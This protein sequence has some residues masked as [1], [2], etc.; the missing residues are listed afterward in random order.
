VRRKNLPDLSQFGDLRTIMIVRLKALGDI[1]LSLPI[2]YALRERFPDADIRYLCRSRYAEALGGETGLD[3]VVELPEGTFGQYALV[4]RLRRRRIDL[5]LDL[6]GSPRSALIT[7]ITAPRVSI[8]MDV[9]RRNWCYHYVLP[10]EIIRDGRR[11]KLYTLEANRE[12]VRMLKIWDRDESGGKRESDVARSRHRSGGNSWRE[13]LAIGFPAAEPE[14]EWARRYVCGLAVDRDALVGVV[15]AATYR[16]K[17]WSAARFIELSRILAAEMDLVPVVI[18]GPGEESYADEIAGH[19]PRTV[20]APRTGIAKLGALINE[21]KLLVTLDSGPKHLAVLQGVPTVTL[22]GPTD[23]RIWDPMNELHR[24][25]YRDIECTPCRDRN[26]ESNRC[27][28]E[29]TPRE[30]AD[31][32]ADLLP[33]LPGRRVEERGE[34]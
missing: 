12:I 28:A 5:V 27:L 30:V 33:L 32:V 34:G 4:Y 8:G 11:V 22:F 23:P 13:G 15:P 16:S 7:R 6:L 1:V 2:I 29:I 24:A 25:V 9:G 14:R 21:M 31:V 10:R 17:S 19:V 20:K 26:C 18:W 3:G